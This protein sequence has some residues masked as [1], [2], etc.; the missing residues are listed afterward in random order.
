MYWVLKSNSILVLATFAAL[1]IAGCSSA[2][3]L[4]SSSLRPPAEEPIYGSLLTE[5]WLDKGKKY[6]RDGDYGLAERAFRK[7]V[8][9]DKNNTEAWLGLAASYDRLQRF[10]LADRAYK[11]VIK[12]T[13]NTPTVLNNLGYHYILRG[14]YAAARQTL[15]AA[16]KADPK[17]P[18]IQN[19]IGLIGDTSTPGKYK[20]AGG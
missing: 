2:P 10:D 14:D 16:Q 4:E 3:E 9:E 15:A 11:V 20:P 19:N 7:A 6:Y 5:K 8:E 1:G 18:Y 12:M 13:G 17:N